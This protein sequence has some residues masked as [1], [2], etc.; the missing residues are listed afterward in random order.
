MNEKE[1]KD[2][3]LLGELYYAEFKLKPEI[4]S[5][6]PGAGSNRRYYLLSDESGQKVVGTIGENRQEN[7]AFINLSRH[8]RKK[9]LTFIPEV[10]SC[11]SDGMAY[12]QT[13]AGN[14]AVF[15]L[16]AAGRKCG[17]FS[18][19]ETSLL[20]RTLILLPHLQFRGSESLDFS[21][22]YPQESMNTRMIRWDLNYFKYCFLKPSGLPFDEVALQNDFDLLEK[23]LLA[24][25]PRWT[26]F[27]HR[28][29]QSRNIM[30]AG[31]GRLSVIDFQG[32][33]RGPVA[34]DVAS[35]VWQAKANIPAGLKQ[36]LIRVYVEEASKFNDFNILDF[37]RELP[38]CVLFRVLQT[39][40]AY[41]FRG[42][43]EKKAHFL[44]S[45]D[46]GIMNL[47]EIFTNSD[48]GIDG[49]ALSTKFPCLRELACNLN[50]SRIERRKK[51]SEENAY[52]LTVCV[53]SFSYKK[54]LPED[55]SGNG[56]GF[57]FDCRATHNPGR[58]EPYKK[59]TGKDEPVI[60]FLEDDG[61][62]L[63]F[64]D[65]CYKLVDATVERYLERGFTHLSVYF[66][67]TGGQHRSVYSAEAMVRH[68][69]N[70]Y[71]VRIKLTHREQHISRILNPKIVNFNKD[72]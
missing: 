2:I 12:F 4:I 72:K 62:I 25:E 13:Y 39:L 27:I 36:S 5:A 42:W 15:D 7:D 11:S 28:D 18:D 63:S 3:S 57:I 6:L 46:A 14:Q 51:Q 23:E 47:F 30:V 68:L 37:N 67:C 33:R 20:E 32:G 48:A 10:L 59:L 9:G 26:T 69:H 64:L 52:G 60:R 44:E 71:G 53:G 45:I 70:K 16:I 41:G 8:F 65:N 35:F 58:Y 22:C 24:G 40:G 55:E 56:G 19:E 29:F 31:N 34:Y 1:N 17:D 38:L 54:G 43:V 49:N 61:E 66:G 50:S 21:V